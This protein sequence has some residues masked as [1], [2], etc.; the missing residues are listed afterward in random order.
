MKLLIME[1][2]SISRH[3]FSL[4]VRYKYSPQ[5][6]VLKTLSLCSSPNVRDQV[7]HPNKSRGKIVVLYNLIFIF[8]D[9]TRGNKNFWTE[10]YQALPEFNISRDLGKISIRNLRAEEACCSE[11]YY[12][13]FKKY[14]ANFRNGFLICR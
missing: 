9:S 3:F 12:R 10:C 2:S 8:L 5:H 14:K 6:P 4:I 13:E 1:F 7:S 11:I